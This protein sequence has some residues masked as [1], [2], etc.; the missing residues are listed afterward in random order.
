MKEYVR[1][2]VSFKEKLLF[3]FFGILSK[4]KFSINK[5]EQEIMK[6]DNDVIEK[7]S[8]LESTYKPPIPEPFFNDDVKVESNL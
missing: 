5:I 7:Q 1:L 3:F 2:N 6:N 4:E 8:S